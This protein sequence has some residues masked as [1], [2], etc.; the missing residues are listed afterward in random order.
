MVLRGRAPLRGRRGAA[1]PVSPLTQDPVA[2]V[3]YVVPWFG[4]DEFQVDPAQVAFFERS[5]AGAEQDR[6]HVQVDL[7]QPARGMLISET[8]LATGDCPPRQRARARA[9]VV[10]D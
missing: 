9:R 6:H 2:D 5:L 8:V 7:V 1:R 3:Q 10:L 4:A